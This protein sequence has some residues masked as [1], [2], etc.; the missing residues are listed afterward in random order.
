MS[1][2]LLTL[3]SWLIDYRPVSFN[4]QKKMLFKKAKQI[5]AQEDLEERFAGR[6]A[7][8]ILAIGYF[9][10]DVRWSTNSSLL[11]ILPLNKSFR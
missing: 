6:D 5:E 8:A 11:V 1:K 9:N 3:E 4:C 2:P 7:L 10:V